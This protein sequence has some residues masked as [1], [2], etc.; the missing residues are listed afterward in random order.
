MNRVQKSALLS[1]LY[2]SQGLP[3]GVFAFALPTLLR[4]NEVS[5]E[6]IGWARLLALPWALKFLWAPVLDRYG[7]RRLGRRRG[8]ILPLQASAVLIL[9][10]MGWVGL[11]SGL[12]VLAMIILLANLVAAT[13]DIATDGLAVGLLSPEERGLGNSLQV[14]AYRVGIILGGGVLL[15]VIGKLGWTATFAC[16]A[17]A[18]FLASIPILRFREPPA[19]GGAPAAGSPARAVELLVLDLLAAV[20]R[21]AMLVWLLLLVI[22]KGGDAIASGMINPFLV[23][24]GVSKEQIGLMGII[25]SGSALFGAFAGGWAITRLGRRRG[26]L[27]LGLIQAVPLLG[28]LLAAQGWTSLGY[29]FALSAAEQFTGTMATV[30]L[31]TMMMDACRPAQGGTDYTLQA[32]VVVVAQIGAGILSGR[33]ATVLGHSGNFATSAGLSLFGALVA[34]AVLAVPAFRQRL[35]KPTGSRW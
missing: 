7:S 22:Y 29:L 33:L 27:L 14:A 35:L 21:P 6:I 20:R 32:S 26:L 25:G 19:A 34:S 1:S 31:F 30:A 2:F 10:S 13:Q 3:Y 18:L 15:V 9:I 16:L 8:W 17:G 4:E 24:V 28:F 12:A 23:D 5:L 11:D